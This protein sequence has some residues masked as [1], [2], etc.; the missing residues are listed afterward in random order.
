M[1]NSIPSA[2]S[3]LESPHKSLYAAVE[4]SNGGQFQSAGVGNC[5][6]WQEG[7]DSQR[8]MV[9]FA[10]W[11]PISKIRKDLW[12]F[13]S[14]PQLWLTRIG[15]LSPVWVE[16]HQTGHT[17]P[18][19]C[20][21]VSGFIWCKNSRLFAICIYIYICTALQRQIRGAFTPTT[22]TFD[23]GIVMRRDR[24][25]RKT[26]KPERQGPISTR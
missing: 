15:L 16:C 26:K 8:R 5:R 21:S 17:P 20:I 9:H 22:Y 1:L 3:P 19:V 2:S 6:F 23:C 7:E 10:K 12:I 13:R 14:L 4:R 18:Q 11:A 25:A 24:T